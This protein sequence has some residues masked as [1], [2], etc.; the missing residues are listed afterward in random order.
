M[1]VAVRRRGGTDRAS[2]IL[3][4]AERLA[5]TRGFNAFSYADV[6]AELGVTKPALHYHFAGKAELGEALLARY[7]A[8][9]SEALEAID[10]S[11]ADAARKLEAYADLYSQVLAQDRMCLCGMLAADYDTL[12]DPMRKAVTSFFDRNE[13][14][15]A[16]VID[17]GRQDGTLQ[18]DGTSREVAQMIISVL[19][20]AMLLARTYSDP[21]RFAS[22]ARRLL[23]EITTLKS[24]SLG[25][26]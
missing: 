7:T 3:D 18:V 15:L 26:R 25:L 9:F 1:A 19:E 20:G 8:R 2:A 10:G 12:P 21:G 5:Q 23:A 24:G 22:P 17:Q 13:A 6:A 4:V 11:G 14:W 16:S